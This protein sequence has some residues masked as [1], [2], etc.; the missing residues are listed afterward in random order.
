MLPFCPD[1]KPNLALGRI[2]P[3]SDETVRHMEFIAVGYQE[4][5]RSR[6]IEWDNRNRQTYKDEPYCLF[7]YT[8]DG[9]GYFVDADAEH[10]LGPGR[11]FIVEIPSETGY[12]LPYGKSWEWLWIAFRG[13]LAESILADIV[14]RNGHVLSLEVKSEPIRI[15]AAICQRL[16]RGERPSKFQLSGALYQILM[17]LAHEFIAEFSSGSA[18][19]ERARNLIEERYADRSLSLDELAKAAGLSKYHFA[20]L[21]KEEVGTAP[22]SFIREKRMNRALDLLTFTDIPVG[23]IGERVGYPNPIHFCSAFRNWRG[24]S[25]GSIRRR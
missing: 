7:Q 19:V 10:E 21:F 18:P 11:G 24:C 16:A 3:D 25:P 1:L 13:D 8:V 2:V 4:V 17:E 6:K 9:C 14:R 20:R 12:F 23:E 22:G 5:R 15:I